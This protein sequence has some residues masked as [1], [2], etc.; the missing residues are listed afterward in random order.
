MKAIKVFHL[1]F[2]RTQLTF[3]PVKL[4]TL[5]LMSLSF[6]CGSTVTCCNPVA[7][8]AVLATKIVSENE[9]KKIFFDIWKMMPHLWVKCQINCVLLFR[10]HEVCYSC[11]KKRQIKSRKSKYSQF[12]ISLAKKVENNI[13]VVTRAALNNV[14]K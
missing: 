10:Y 7:V 11:K 12:S 1:K 6:L 2:K 14:T 9:I 3:Y 4:P 8:A 13:Q 5:L